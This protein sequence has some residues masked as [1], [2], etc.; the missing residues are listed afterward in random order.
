M[1]LDPA[2]STFAFYVWGVTAGR[3]RSQQEAGRQSL[4]LSPV[5]Q[6]WFPTLLL[7]HSFPSLSLTFLGLILFLLRNKQSHGAEG[8]S[9]LFCSYNEE[10]YHFLMITV[11]V[12]PNLSCQCFA[13]CKPQ[14]SWNFVMPQIIFWMRI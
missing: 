1:C 2:T 14:L 5:F 9:H 6:I 7:H 3:G 8:D 4:T 12:T 10:G 11:N 13:S